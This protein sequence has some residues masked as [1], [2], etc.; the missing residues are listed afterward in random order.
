MPR[1]PEDV[2]RAEQRTATV[3]YVFN[4]QN[5]GFLAMLESIKD[6]V[7]SKTGFLSWRWE[8][9][10]RVTQER[11]RNQT[12]ES[13]AMLVND[14]EA[15]TILSQQAVPGPVGPNGQPTTVIDC[16]VQVVSAKGRCVVESVPPEEVLV[17]S[18]ARSPDLSMAP[19]V[20]WRSYKTR[21]ELAKL[22]YDDD[23]LDA[24]NFGRTGYSDNQVRRN[25]SFAHGDSG[26]DGGEILVFTSW[27]E[28]DCDEDGIAELRRVVW[29]DGVILENE[30]TDA[31]NLSAWSPNIQPHEFIGR[32]P[33][34]DAVE[35][36][37]VMTSIKRQTLDNLY[38]ANNPMWRIDASDTR[39]NVEDFFNPE[40]GRPLRA[41]QGP[42][43]V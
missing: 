25:I 21:E 42:R 6:G 38:L 43:W 27:L 32:C 7:L 22:G 39:V 9:E 5:N 10:R 26:I 34:D 16:V 2:E 24:L 31:I 36:Q 18:R 35:S 29:S 37:E 12:P 17:S 1:G 11:Y 40:I 14:N 23:V 13:L 30:I 41:P 3:N 33:A 20:H 19:A 28:C 8:V 15:V 4:T